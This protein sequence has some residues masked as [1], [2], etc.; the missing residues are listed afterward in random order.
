MGNNDNVLT[1][2]LNEDVIRKLDLLLNDE[3]N[4]ADRMGVKPGGRK[5]IVEEAIKTLY[6]KTINS[7]QD[8]DVVERINELITDQVGAAM[9]T[10]IQD[11]EEILFLCIKNDLGNRVFYR[12]PSVLPAPSSKE[13]AIEVIVNEKSK[14]DLALEEY[15]MNRWAR[16]KVHTHE[17]QEDKK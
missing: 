14:W 16:E 11:I 4:K 15:M 8:A 13:Q 3:I 7:K 1:V 2:R 6:F 10:I 12:S 17:S 5:E 9:S